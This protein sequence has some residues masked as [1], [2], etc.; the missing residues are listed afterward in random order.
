MKCREKKREKKPKNFILSI[1]SISL[2]LSVTECKTR[3]SS[4]AL[5][6]KDYKELI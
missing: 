2:W 4:I 1:S 5:E 3:K 6:I